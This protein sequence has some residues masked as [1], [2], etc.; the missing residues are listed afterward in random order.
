VQFQDLMELNVVIMELVKCYAGKGERAPCYFYKTASGVE[1]DLL[2]DHGNEFAIHEIK[3]SST[4]TIEMARSLMQFKE[5]YPVKHA[6][7]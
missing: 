6:S 3:F 7:L 4:P 1:I 5:E 2:L